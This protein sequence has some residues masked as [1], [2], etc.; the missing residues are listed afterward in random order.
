MTVCPCGKKAR[1]YDARRDGLC[2]ACRQSRAYRRPA[3]TISPTW[4][5]QHRMPRAPG[6]IERLMERAALGLP[7]FGGAT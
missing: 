5:S 2:R 6:Q 3:R 7:L 4:S 1:R